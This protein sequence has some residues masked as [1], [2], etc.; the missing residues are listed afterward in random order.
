MSSTPNK[1]GAD[2]A[3]MKARLKTTIADNHAAMEHGLSVEE[4]NK[5][6]GAVLLARELIEWVEPTTP[7]K[8]EE[9]SYGISDPSES[10]YP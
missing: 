5:C 3:I 9:D 2:W 8:T 4:Y 6:R 10:N 1:L 7:P